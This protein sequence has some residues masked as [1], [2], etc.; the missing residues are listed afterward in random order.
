M[1]LDLDV[2]FSDAVSQAF[3]S[4]SGSTES[5]TLTLSVHHSAPGFFPASSLGSLPDPSS[6]LF[7]PF[8]LCL[9]LNRGTSDATFA[10]IWPC[11]ERVKD[12]FQPD[13]LVLQCGADG[14]AGDP[15]AIWNWSLG[16]AEGSLGWCVNRVCHEW[17]CKT[18]LLGGGI[19]HFV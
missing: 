8:T 12:A 4:P 11:I 14:L 7:D 9:P 3:Y 2:H 18:L 10:R 13:F 19:L 5:Q 17:N 6:P 16:P 15:T 1:Y